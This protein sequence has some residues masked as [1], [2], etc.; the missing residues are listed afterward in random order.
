MNRIIHH[1]GTTFIPA[2]HEGA[3]AASAANEA[4]DEEE[5]QHEEGQAEALMDDGA[6][7][8]RSPRK[9]QRCAG[10]LD[11]ESVSEAL[12]A[13]IS[14]LCGGGGGSEAAE[15]G[16]GSRGGGEGA[17]PGAVLIGYS[18]GARVALHTAANHP[19]AATA[20]AAIGEIGRAHV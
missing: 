10:Y 16:D 13:L 8:P 20:V 7:T 9:E 4:E 18:L 2:S 17:G 5:D 1:G 19:E 15:G 6:V 3:A 14:E 11:M 12:A